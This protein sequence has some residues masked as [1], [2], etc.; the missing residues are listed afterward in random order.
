MQLR[1][2]A[3]KSFF[4]TGAIIFALGF[5]HI[6]VLFNAIISLVIGPNSIDSIIMYAILLFFAAGFIG[7]HAYIYRD[8]LL[9]GALLL[10]ALVS[11]K[12]FWVE[13]WVYVTEMMPQLVQGV[14]AFIVI[15]RIQNIE[16]IENSLH[17]LAY[18]IF[19][20]A[21]ILALVSSGVILQGIVSITYMAYGYNML[22]A[23]LI[24]LYRAWDEKKKKYLGY[25]LALMILILAFGSRGTF[26]AIAGFILVYY[27][28]VENKL[29]KKKIALIGAVIVFAIIINNKTFLEFIATALSKILPFNSRTLTLLISGEA[30]S[31]SGRS[32]IYEGCL[33]LIKEH[34]LLG[35]GICG[36]RTH[37]F[38][39][40]PTMGVNNG[41]GG[42][43]AH[44]FFLEV[45]VDFGVPIGILFIVFVL[46]KEIK[47]CL[48]K[49]RKVQKVGV[50]MFTGWFFQHLVSGSFWTSPYF[51]AALAYAIAWTNKNGRRL[52]EN[53]I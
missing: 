8:E 9:L 5:Y 24:F 34:W 12:L 11:T 26:I 37:A 6:N 49:D 41:I 29:T 4:E 22:P 16:I 31:D 38:I 36:E 21:I 39:Y 10:A 33:K 45:L 53:R 40:Q 20:D 52:D 32:Y 2:R 51:F 7:K 17:I 48:C 18:I 47:I 50:I 14:M 13:N 43:Y 23:V 1:I 27:V 15:R 3:D 35:N 42:L 30:M 28:I 46:F 44:N 25:S 19:G